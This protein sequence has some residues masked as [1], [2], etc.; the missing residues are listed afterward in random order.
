[1][2]DPDKAR[3]QREVLMRRKERYRIARR[4]GGRS[5]PKKETRVEPYQLDVDAIAW[6][7]PGGRGC[8]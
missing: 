4:K 1:M 3:K 8:V 5:A 7:S 6:S 2:I